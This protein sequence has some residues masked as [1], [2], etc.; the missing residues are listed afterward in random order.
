MLPT[1]AAPPTV[2]DKSKCEDEVRIMRIMSVWRG[3]GEDLVRTW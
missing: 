1:L 3:F 2:C